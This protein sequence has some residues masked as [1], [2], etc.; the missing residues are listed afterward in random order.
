MSSNFSNIMLINSLFCIISKIKLWKSLCFVAFLSRK[1][2]S[3]LQRSGARG[4][5]DIDTETN[6]AYIL[7]T[8]KSQQVDVQYEVIGKP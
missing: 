7:T 8:R 1:Y 5:V 4:C 2:M 3:T 6:V